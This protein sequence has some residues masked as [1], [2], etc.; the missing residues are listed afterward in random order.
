MTNLESVFIGARSFQNL[1]TF[2]LSHNP[3][4]KTFTT[5]DCD[6]EDDIFNYL[7]FCKVN[8]FELIGI[9]LV[10]EINI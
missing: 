6:F 5:G 2:S 10:F 4:L 9:L 8:E 7:T 1:K 3:K